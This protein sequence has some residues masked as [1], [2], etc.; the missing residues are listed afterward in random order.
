[1]L[2]VARLD[3]AWDHERIEAGGRE[4]KDGEEHPVERYWAGLTRFDIDAPHTLGGVVVTARQYL[5]DDAT[6][7]VARLRRVSGVEREKALSVWE[8][9][10]RREDAIWRLCKLGV[11]EVT[12]GFDGAR[13]PFRGGVAG[14]SLLDEDVQM[15]YDAHRLLP[16]LLGVAVLAAAAPLSEDEG[17]R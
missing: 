14:Q 9:L 8:D 3:D 12:E 7:T 6:P 11:V 15:L 17:K 1:M 10:P 5:R 2:L 4:L 16:T 13:W